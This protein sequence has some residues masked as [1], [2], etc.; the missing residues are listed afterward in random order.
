MERL[1]NRSGKNGFIWKFD[2]VQDVFIE[3][4]RIIRFTSEINRNEILLPSGFR[5]VFEVVG[6]VID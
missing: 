1:G 6:S 4:T 5:D 3:S 2:D